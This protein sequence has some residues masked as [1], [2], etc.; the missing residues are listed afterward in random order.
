VLERRLGLGL[1]AESAYVQ[2]GTRTEFARCFYKV[3][4]SDA[5]LHRLRASLSGA[6]RHRVSD[7]FGSGVASYEEAAVGFGEHRRPHVLIGAKRGRGAP[8]RNQCI[9][10]VL[11]RDTRDGHV[12][13]VPQST[14]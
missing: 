12:G 10:R 7:Q 11:T 6:A 5:L 8:C 14:P 2:S 13:G 9:G 3:D 1:V 4:L